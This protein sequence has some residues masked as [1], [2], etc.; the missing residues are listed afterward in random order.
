ML[1][2]VFCTPNGGG[3][4]RGRE[5]GKKSYFLLVSGGGRFLGQLLVLDLLVH[6]LDHRASHLWVGAADHAAVAPD[7]ALGVIDVLLRAFARR[8]VWVLEDKDGLVVAEGSVDVFEGP[9][10]GFRVE[11][12]GNGDE[13][14]VEHRPDDVELPVNALDADGRDFHHH[15]VDNPIRRCAQRRTFGSHRERVDLG[16]IKPRNTLKADA[17][18]NVIKEE[19]GHRA[20]RYLLLVRVTVLLVVSEQDGDN[21]ITEELTGRCVHDHFTTAPSLDTRVLV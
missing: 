16:G 12:V 6:S 11:E 2:L 1:R 18:E 3:G 10:G 14:E 21:H 17:K 13:G 19:E 8:H 4:E 9:V 15:E 7:L 20:G 5:K